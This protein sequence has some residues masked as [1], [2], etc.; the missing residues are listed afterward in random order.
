MRNP[1]PRCTCPNPP[2]PKKS[3][4]INKLSEHCRGSSGHAALGLPE[5]DSSGVT[6]RGARLDA[7]GHFLGQSSSERS[8]PANEQGETGACRNHCEDIRGKHHGVFAPGCFVLGRIGTRGADKTH[9]VHS[10]LGG[11]VTLRQSIGLLHPVVGTVARRYLHDSS[12][13]ARCKHRSA[14][15]LAR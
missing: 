4:E 15:P 8:P 3:R 1:R 5:H 2:Q 10:P 6:R 14:T 12:A 7:Y 13:S 9:R 11:P